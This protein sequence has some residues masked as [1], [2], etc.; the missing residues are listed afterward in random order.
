MK[1][2]KEKADVET[3]CGSKGNLVAQSEGEGKSG[4]VLSIESP[5]EN[6]V[7]VLNEENVNSKENSMDKKE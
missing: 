6:D 4:D 7:S 1:K 5:N 3:N 2:K